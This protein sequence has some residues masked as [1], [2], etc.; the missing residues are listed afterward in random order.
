MPLIAVAKTMET[1]VGTSHA[2]FNIQWH[3]FSKYHEVGLSTLNFG[4]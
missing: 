2:I 4:V 3:I 1:Y